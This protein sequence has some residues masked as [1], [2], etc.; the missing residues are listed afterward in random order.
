MLGK[1]RFLDLTAVN[2]GKMH[3]FKIF[4]S[5]LNFSDLLKPLQQIFFLVHL[6]VQTSSN[7]SNQVLSSAI[8]C[9]KVQ[10]ISNKF[11][12]VQRSSINCNQ[13]QSTAI[14]CNQLKSSTINC[15]QVQS[16]RAERTE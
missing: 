2:M 13:V 4:L 10:T 16:C 9:N 14:N 3:V 12:Q 1:S 11:N 7:R 15:Y 8:K 6:S 5:Y